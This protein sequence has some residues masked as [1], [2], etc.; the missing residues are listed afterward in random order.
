VQLPVEAFGI[1]NV[2]SI[3]KATGLNRETARRKV[4][5]LV[6]RGMVVRDGARITLTPG[7][8]QQPAA[9]E[10]VRVQL[11]AVRMAANEL[12]REGV[13]TIVE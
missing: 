2:S 6:R 10:M 3:A 5:K 7:F 9:I 4:D 8:T 1:C 13:I 11:E 12:L